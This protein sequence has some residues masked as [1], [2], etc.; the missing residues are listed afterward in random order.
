ML[1]RAGGPQGAR[2]GKIVGLTRVRNESLVIEDT[3][4]H[5]AGIC[6]EI[7]VYDDCSEDDTLDVVAGSSAPVAVVIAAKQWSLKRSAEETR[8]RRILLDVARSLDAEWC[9]YF[10]ADERVVGD[11]RT[12]LLGLNKMYHGVRVPLFD[13]YLSE[14]L[15]DNYYHGRLI[16]TQR[17][18]GRECRR[19][20]MA[21]RAGAAFEYLGLDQREPVPGITCRIFESDHAVAHFGKAIS[22]DQWNA[23]CEYYAKHFPEPYASKWAS[24]Y[25][26]AIHSTSDFGSE[27]LS[28]E[29]ARTRSVDITPVPT[30]TVRI[31]IFARRVEASFRS[32]L[33]R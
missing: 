26:R 13:A 6:D 12:E 33:R 3:L 27:L 11:L 2:S 17:L 21:W 15:Q 5:F 1:G 31:K 9:L 20:L 18:Y 7:V 29:E 19:I 30:I 16:E 25:G 23:T 4:N 8:H 24:R 10:D 22:V 28:L 32:I 14:D